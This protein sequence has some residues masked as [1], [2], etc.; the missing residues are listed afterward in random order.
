MMVPSG[1]E[2]GLGASRV[3]VT[4]RYPRDHP[5]AK[6]HEN[7]REREKEREREPGTGP[8]QHAK[9]APGASSADP[10]KRDEGV[11]QLGV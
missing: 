2:Q 5:Q 7:I 8:S 1:E 10:R 9:S 11:S 4:P 6:T 3:S